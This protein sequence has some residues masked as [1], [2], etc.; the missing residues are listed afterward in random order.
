MVANGAATRRSQGHW[1]LVVVVDKASFGGVGVSKVDE[2]QTA[3]KLLRPP[4]T[5]RADVATFKAALAPQG[6]APKRDGYRIPPEKA[7]AVRAAA[8]RIDHYCA[9][10][11]A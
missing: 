5:I 6:S 8:S 1:P 2:F 7:S 11:G 4:T 3:T 9:K 10:A